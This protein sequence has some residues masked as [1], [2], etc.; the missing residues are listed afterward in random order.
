MSE[1]AGGVRAESKAGDEQHWR[2]RDK[3]D[4][5]WSDVTTGGTFQHSYL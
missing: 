5:R 1:S 2:R 3:A 4:R